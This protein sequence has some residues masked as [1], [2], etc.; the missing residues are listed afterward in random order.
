MYLFLK[1]LQYENINIE[2]TYCIPRSAGTIQKDFR[3]AKS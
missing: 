1:Q 2:I 3:S